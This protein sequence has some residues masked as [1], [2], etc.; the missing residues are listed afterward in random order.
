MRDSFF[1]EIRLF[2]EETTCPGQLRCQGQICFQKS[3]CFK[4]ITSTISKDALSESLGAQFAEQNVESLK[5]NCSWQRSCRGQVAS[6]KRSRISGKNLPQ[7][8]KLPRTSG[9]C[10]KSLI[11][12]KRSAPGSAA[13]LDKW[14]V[15]N[16]SDFEK[17]FCPRQRNCPGQWASSKRDRLLRK[18]FCPR[19]RSCPG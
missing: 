9:F 2:F 3:D 19:Q 14:F 17:K 10:K 12:E 13:A 1:R 7:A 6:S 8:A 4:N 11:F 15:Q 5:K 18:K 16:K